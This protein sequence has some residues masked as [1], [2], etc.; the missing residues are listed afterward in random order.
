MWNA[1][2][3]KQTKKKRKGLQQEQQRVDL[4]RRLKQQRK[5]ERARRLTHSAHPLTDED[6]Q[7]PVIPGFLF[8]RDKMR[9]FPMR[10]RQSEYDGFQNVVQSH[11]TISSGDIIH[12]VLS[13]LRIRERNGA[14]FNRESIANDILSANI[15]RAMTTPTSTSVSPFKNSECMQ[16]I[17]LGCAEGYLGKLKVK[18]VKARNPH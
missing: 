18:K 3:T 12:P 1:N 7:V 17:D 9:Y 14:C 15:T 4:T 2:T 5:R 11:S 16:T 8:D 6:K 10:N 13:M